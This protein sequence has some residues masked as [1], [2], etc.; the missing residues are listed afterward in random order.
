MRLRRCNL[1][2]FVAAGRVTAPRR[3]AGALMLLSESEDQT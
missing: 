3:G 1:A 2:L